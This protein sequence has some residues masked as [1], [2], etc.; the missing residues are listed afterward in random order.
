MDN[1]AAV[2]GATMLIAV[3]LRANLM[4]IFI[5]ATMSEAAVLKIIV[6]R[7]PSKFIL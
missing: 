3:V 7:S 4:I 2:L 6:F 1:W 5:G